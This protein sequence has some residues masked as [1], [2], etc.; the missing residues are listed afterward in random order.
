[1][2]IDKPLGFF[3]LSLDF[4]Y[5]SLD[6]FNLS[7]GFSGICFF[8]II[9]NFKIFKSIRLIFYEPMTDFTD[10]SSIL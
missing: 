7:F 5:L 1:M 4:F 9:Q 10:F 8:K 2:K 6:F 3:S